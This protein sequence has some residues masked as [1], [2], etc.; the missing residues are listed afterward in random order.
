VQFI[1]DDDIYFHVKGKIT[2]PATPPIFKTYEDHRMA[3]SFAPLALILPEIII[4][5]P[6]VVS[7]SHP[8]F[9]DHLKQMGFEMQQ[10]QS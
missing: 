3:M 2:I 4:E 10:V 5:D 6:M 9:W 7:K 1:S 8:Q